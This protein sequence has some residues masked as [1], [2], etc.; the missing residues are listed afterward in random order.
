MQRK[1][2]R[3]N[4]FVE[5]MMTATEDQHWQLEDYNHQAKYIWPG[6][7]NHILAQYNEDAVVVYQAYRPEIAQYAGISSIALCI[8]HVCN[9]QLQF[10][11]YSHKHV[12]P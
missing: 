4:T 9:L 12:H 11:Y 7:G 1:T 2:L 3:T 10:L 5:T 8:L 6:R